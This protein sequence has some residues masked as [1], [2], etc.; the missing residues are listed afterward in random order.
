MSSSFTTL[1]VMAQVEILRQ[2]GCGAAPNGLISCYEYPARVCASSSI[3]S[4]RVH[5]PAWT[6]QII[7]RST[8]S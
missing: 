8:Y 3:P 2:R 4:C 7:P 5:D 6:F 1:Q